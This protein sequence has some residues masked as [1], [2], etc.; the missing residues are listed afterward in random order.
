MNDQQ[1]LQQKLA[2]AK[3]LES[4]LNL[5]GEKRQELELK[6]ADLEKKAF[7]LLKQLIGME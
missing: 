5:L 3:K 2:E 6:R 4:E 1:T 7:V